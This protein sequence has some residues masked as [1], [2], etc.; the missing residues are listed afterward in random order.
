MDMRV[1]ARVWYGNRHAGIGR[2]VRGCRAAGV[3]VQARAGYGN[4]HVGIGW[5]VRGCRAA[6]V[7]E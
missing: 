2:R 1:Q 5:R 7:R 6:G 3:R 4:S